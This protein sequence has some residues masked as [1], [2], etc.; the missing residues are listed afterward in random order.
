MKK[1]LRILMF[2]WE[3]PPFHS[4]G[5][6][7]VCYFLTKALSEQ[8]IKITFVLPQKFDIRVDYMRVL[9]ADL[10]PDVKVGDIK[11]SLFSAYIT[12][13]IYE[14]T[15]KDLTWL[16]YFQGSLFERVKEYGERVKSI[17]GDEEKFDVIHVHDWLTVPAG[18]AA[19]EK[20]K[21]PLIVHIH[22]TEFDRTGGKN[23]NQ[24]VY[25]IEKWG[26]ERANLVVVVSQF[27]KNIIIKHYG[28]EPSKIQVIHNAI[29]FPETISSRSFE[30][31]IKDKQIVLFVGR[32]TLQKGP[33]Y[34]LLA[35]KKVL[36]HNPNVIFIM[37]GSGDM[38]RQIIEMAAELNI[39]DKVIFTGFKQGKELAQIYQ[40]ADLY[41]L[42]SVSEPF[43]LTPL[44]SLSYG[45]PVL[46]SKQSG[47]SEALSHC[48]KVDFW[49]T[50][51]MANKIL[52]V[53]KYNELKDE[54]SQCGRKEVQ[55]FNWRDTAQQFIE[56]YRSINNY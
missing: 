33:D 20:F 5:L 7:V 25:E 1:S 30:L 3:F 31:K 36:E 23:I 21:K 11:K 41:V 40:M 37:T 6:G 27:T 14:K 52:A 56:A 12:S 34:F 39:A 45:T 10:F 54:L 38:E 9:F 42:S 32:I 8:N 51:Q 24:G 26:M 17:I 4:G 48:L 19:M 18:I 44:E 47:V 16:N 49:D 15:K 22:A 28:I 29:D 35:A 2:G 55:K 53:L 50:D 13:E 43:G 46:I